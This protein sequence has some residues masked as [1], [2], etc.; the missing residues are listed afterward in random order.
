MRALVLLLLSGMA[1]ADDLY[2][3]APVTKDVDGR[4][5]T[6][7]VT[8]QFY[9]DGLAYGAPQF[10]AP[11]LDNPFYVPT[12]QPSRYEVSATAGGKEGARSNVYVSSS[13]IPA[14]PGLEATIPQ[15][16]ANCWKENGRLG[17]QFL[18]CQADLRAA[19]AAVK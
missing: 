16:L 13:C 6:T 4:T 3:L 5:L 12:C 18:Q 2:I 8:Y 14:A 7:S 19:K 11:T 10:K 1:W 9:R 17:K 15:S